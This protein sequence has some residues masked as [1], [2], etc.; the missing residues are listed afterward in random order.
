MVPQWSDHGRLGPRGP[1]LRDHPGGRPRRGRRRRA[2]RP[3]ESP[4]STSTSGT[5]RPASG[6]SSPRARADAAFDALSDAN[7]GTRPNYYPTIQ[8]GRPR[9]GRR[10]RR[11]ARARPRRAST[12]TSGTSPDPL[13][14]AGQGS[15]SPRCRTP[16]F[17]EP[18]STTRRSRPPTSTA[19]GGDEVL[20]RSAFGINV[21]S[22][23]RRSRGRRSSAGSPALS[24]VGGLEPAALLLDDPDRQRRRGRPGRLLAQEA[25]RHV[26][27][28]VGRV[29]RPSFTQVGQPLPDSLRRERNGTKPQYYLTLQTGD[30]DGDGAAELIGRGID[31]CRRLEVE[32]LHPTRSSSSATRYG[33]PLRRRRVDAA[34]VL[35]D[36]PDRW[37]STRRLAAPSCWP[38]SEAGMFT[39]PWSDSTDSFTLLTP[40]G[41]PSLADAPWDGPGDVP[42]DPD[43]RRRRQAGL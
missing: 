28:V 38:R 2:A 27:L 1:V 23:E 42:D 21:Y 3:R 11:V 5:P 9:R 24:D 22:L 41:I 39:L 26:R 32:R 10:R 4:A 37:T 17:A 43:R 20:A 40:S 15:R 19:Q 33:E 13:L 14:R 30:L 16:E 7:G 18:R 29:R 6:S 25:C 8:T 34:A 36:D 35:P 12:P 31:R